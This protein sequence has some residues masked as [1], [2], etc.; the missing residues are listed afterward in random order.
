[1]EIVTDKL[2]IDNEHWEEFV[3]NHPS[4]NIFHTPFYNN[5]FEGEKKITPFILCIKDEDN[6]IIG[7]LQAV[8]YKEYH[9]LL[10]SFTSRSIVMG[11]PIVLNETA[12]DLLIRS[13]NKLIRPK[14]I[15][16]QLRNLYDQN[17]FKKLY[18]NYGYEY[19]DHL[20]ILIDLTE[21]EDY[22]WKNVHPKGRNKIRRATREGTSFKILTNVNELPETYSILIDVYKR[23][24]LPLL[25]Y[26]IFKRAFTCSGVHVGMKVFCAVN[27]DKIIG[28]LYALYYRNIIFD[29]YAGG[30]LDYYKFYPNDL[31]L[32][33]IFL[34]GKKNGF[35]IFDFGCAGK[36]GIHYGVRDYKMKFGGSV[37]NY[38]R[39]IKIHKQYLYNLGKAGLKV[40][41]FIKR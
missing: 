1:M 6:R 14:A 40:W 2:K 15:Y 7:L 22:L 36:P 17:P 18:L 30:Y 32:W 37:V 13:Y 28:T 11:G 24:K 5:I 3:F 35:K 4:G 27:M 41:K 34:W 16:T 8:I 23:A 12:R 21:S 33:E 38:G 39:F 10:G 20:N 29:W 9:G 26:Q 31:L 25:P 19:E